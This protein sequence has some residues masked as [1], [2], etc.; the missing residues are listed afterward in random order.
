MAST[1][2]GSPLTARSCKLRTLSCL[3]S[4]A[5]LLSC[6]S[7]APSFAQ[8]PYPGKPIRWI[9][10]YAAG[11][12]TDLASRALALR[13]SQTLGQPVT[14]ENRAGG[15][16]T[17]G[18]NLLAKAPADGYTIGT[19][20][21]AL[22]FN[23]GLQARLP[24]DPERDLTA[25]MQYGILPFIV[26]VNSAQSINTTAE[27]IALARQRPGQLTYGTPGIGSPHHLYMEL[28]KLRTGTDI[29]HV[30]YKGGAPLVQDLVAGRITLST[31]NWGLVAAQIR[32]G[33][34]RPLAVTSLARLPALPD[35]PTLAESG[36]SD[37]SAFAWQGVMAPSGL[38]PEI[39]STLSAALA[40]IMDTPELKK[41]CTD[42]G[43]TPSV[44]DGPA[45]T[46]L[47]AAERSKWIPLIHSLGI[48]AE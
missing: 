30:P 6:A 37:F 5:L 20:D 15:G 48:T 17:V 42:L 4:V 9:V 36:V 35:V 11:G 40:Q 39:A 10:P 3:L 14:V 12:P 32:A 45:F 25:L 46:R 33:H 27:L 44:L 21:N 16:T 24:Y 13:L 41:T 29:V 26:M 43:M 18:L 34:L 22:V 8:S 28:F 31:S 47:I 38:A 7:S 2:S 23:A 1:D 19:V